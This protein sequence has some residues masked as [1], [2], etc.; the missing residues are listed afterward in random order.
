MEKK[1]GLWIDHEKAFIVKLTGGKESRSVIFS[2]VEPR[3]RPHGGFEIISEKKVERR[4]KG[5]LRSWYREVIG[6]VSGADRIFIFGPGA[7]KMEL[8]SEMDDFREVSNKVVGM[9]PAD[10]MSENQVA[11][12]VRVF[13]DSEKASVPPYRRAPG[14]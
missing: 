11:A 2:D 4:R 12:K 8:L 7:A 10:N 14:A 9:E 5:H 6:A 13:F 1:I 3:I